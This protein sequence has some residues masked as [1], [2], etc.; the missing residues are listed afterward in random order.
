MAAAVESNNLPMA[1]GSLIMT[2]R[3]IC[4]L[5]PG[6]GEAAVVYWSEETRRRGGGRRRRRSGSGGSSESFE[7]AEV[8]LAGR[9]AA[10]T[11]ALGPAEEEECE[12]EPCSSLGKF[13]AGIKSGM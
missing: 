1:V 6:I 8:S 5:K 10:E 12:L 3:A 11:K 13:G 4:V 2:T 7:E 9:Y